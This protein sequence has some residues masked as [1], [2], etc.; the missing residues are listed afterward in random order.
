MI[1]NPYKFKH[2][3]YYKYI[4]S[5]FKKRRFYISYDYKHRALWY[6]TYKVASRTI[7]SV[8]RED[9]KKGQYIYASFNPYQPKLHVNYFKFAF[10]RNPESRF[11]S[12]WKD[13]VLRQNYFQFPDKTYRKMKDIDN[14]ILWVENLDLSN[15]DEHL[16]KQI[17]LIDLDNVNFIG[18]FEN[19]QK[20][21]SF[22]LKKLNINT[23]DVPVLNKG[24]NYV[25]ELNLKQRARI[26]KLYKEDFERFYPSEL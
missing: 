18:R 7:D 25:S 26:V 16:K 14:F 8:L 15:T 4:L 1:L 21:F 12:A 3:F 24:L 22:V 6:R 11:I 10:V 20:D 5:I 9:C 13:K 19:F 23:Q 2:F 17:D